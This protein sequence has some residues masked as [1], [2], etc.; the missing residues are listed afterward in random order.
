MDGQGKAVLGQHR[1]EDPLPGRV[2]DRAHGRVKL[3]KD[4]GRGHIVVR[5]DVEQDHRAKAR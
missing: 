5:K 3:P 1:Y 2:P 4:L